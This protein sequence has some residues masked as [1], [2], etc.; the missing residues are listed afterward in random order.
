MTDVGD[1]ALALLHDHGLERGASL[2]VAHAD[3][4]H[5]PALGAVSR[6]QPVLCQHPGSEHRAT[7]H[8]CET[9]AQLHFM[10]P[11]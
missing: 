9:Q 8:H 4:A 6:S 11:K 2:Q 7:G 10:L 5:V 3:Q 1:P